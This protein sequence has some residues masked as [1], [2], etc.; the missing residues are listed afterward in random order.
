STVILRRDYYSSRDTVHQRRRIQVLVQEFHA[1]IERLGEVVLEAGGRR[2][3]VKVEVTARVSEG[4]RSSP[5]TAIAPSHGAPK[6]RIGLRVVTHALIAAD[7][8]FMDLRRP[9]VLVGRVH[10]PP[11]RQVTTGWVSWCEAGAIPVRAINTITQNAEAQV[12][13]PL[14]AEVRGV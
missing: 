11:R 2:P 13:A 3:D 8:G 4:E 9:V 14:P 10:A 6:A 1:D 5:T 7:E 12:A